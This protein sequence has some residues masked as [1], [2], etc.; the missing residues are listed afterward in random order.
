[1]LVKLDAHWINFQL[2]IIIIICTCLHQLMVN[3]DMPLIKIKR[4]MLWSHGFCKLSPHASEIRRYLFNSQW[5]YLRRCIRSNILCKIYKRNTTCCNILHTWSMACF[6]FDI[7]LES[8]HQ[9][10]SCQTKNDRV[11]KLFSKN[12]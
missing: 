9:I 4:K 11:L 8:N 3:W 5:D 12:A 1:M 6:R 10:V 2:I 7:S